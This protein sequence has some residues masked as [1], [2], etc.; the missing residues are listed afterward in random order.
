MIF[1]TLFAKVACKEK[2][3]YC[4][5]LYAADGTHFIIDHSYAHQWLSLSLYASQTTN[6][7]LRVVALFQAKWAHFTFS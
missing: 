4:F 7:P 5:G 2:V 1:H 6:L 3:V